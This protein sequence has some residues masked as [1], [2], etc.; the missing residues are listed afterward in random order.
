MEVSDLLGDPQPQPDGS[1]KWVDGALTKAVRHGYVFILNEA[2]LT[3]PGEL[4][5]LND[6][7]EGHP[8]CLVRNGGEIVHPHPQFRLVLTDNSGGQGDQT[9][10][11]SGVVTQNPSFLDRSCKMFVG[12]PDADIERSVLEGKLEG[13]GFELDSAVIDKFVATANDVRAVFMGDA[14][15]SKVELTVTMSTRTLWRW[16]LRSFHMAKVDEKTGSPVL[17]IAA[18][19]D[20]ALT[21]T[22]DQSERKAI[23]EIA[24]GHFGKVW[25]DADGVQTDGA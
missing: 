14:S 20:F 1:W 8:L 2:F 7:A 16:L 5:G 9:G 15:K 11:Y 21:R 4:T 6:V 19:L 12:Y 17:G 22:I 13:T 10:F 3:T 25:K 24:R 23:H 18:A